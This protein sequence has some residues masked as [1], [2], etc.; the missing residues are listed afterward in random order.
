MLQA[1]KIELRMDFEEY[2][3]Q[4]MIGHKSLT[5]SERKATAKF[6]LTWCLDRSANLSA[7][8]LLV[9]AILFI[10]TTKSDKP[11]CGSISRIWHNSMN[12]TSSILR[13]ACSILPKI[14]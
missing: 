4:K 11:S 14:E 10:E 2:L 9:L 5:E 12:S 3:E 6:A 13:L 1:E 8:R 7:Q